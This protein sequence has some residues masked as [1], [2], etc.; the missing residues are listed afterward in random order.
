[1]TEGL[2]RPVSTEDALAYAGRLDDL[3]N[4]EWVLKRL[5]DGANALRTLV[6]ERDALAVRVS[7]LEAEVLEQCRLNGMGAERE[8]ALMSR[9]M[10]GTVRVPKRPTQA[11][12]DVMDTEGWAWEDLLA[13]AEAI[14]QDE[15][16]ALTTTSGDSHG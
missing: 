1:M 6:S 11:M 5:T 13:A 16:A 7:E 15:Y 2:P 3:C 4:A 10:A 14:T 8:L 9:S 12:R